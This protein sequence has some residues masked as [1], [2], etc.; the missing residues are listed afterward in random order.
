MLYREVFGRGSDRILKL[1]G[2]VL[3][4]SVLH[5]NDRII[6][7]GHFAVAEPDFPEGLKYYRYP[8]VILSF[9]ARG[10]VEIY[11]AYNFLLNVYAPVH[12]QR[13]KDAVEKLPRP[14]EKT[15]LSFATSEMFLNELDLQ[16][17]SQKMY[18]A[19]VLVENL[20]SLPVTCRR[21]RWPRSESI[22]KD[23]GRRANRIMS[24]RSGKTPS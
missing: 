11:K 3:V 5:D 23:R 7:Y 20:V 8:I 2:E 22:C 10:G 18:R 12:R 15:G 4:F 9:I 16:Q 21:K 17:D 19:T 14:S 24:D 13:I 6:I 1:H